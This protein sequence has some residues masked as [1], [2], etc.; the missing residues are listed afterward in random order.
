MNRYKIYKIN[1]LGIKTEVITVVADSFEY[2]LVGSYSFFQDVKGFFGK[3]KEHNLVHHL[4]GD[5]HSYLV[6]KD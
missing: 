5:G 2:R 6:I 3:V 1:G 4:R